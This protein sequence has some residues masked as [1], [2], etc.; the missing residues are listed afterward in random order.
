MT[1]HSMKTLL[2]ISALVVMGAWAAISL[3]RAIQQGLSPQGGDDLYTYWYAGQFLREG[4]DLYKT[5]IDGDKP[6]LPVVYLDRTVTDLKEIIQ[7]NLVP[8]PASS[9]LAFFLLAPLAF[10]SWSLAKAVWLLIN[11]VLLGCIPFLVYRLF[12]DKGWLSPWE[13]IALTCAMIGLSSTRN[14]T[15][16]GQITFLI[17][18]LMLAAVVLA[19]RRPW[20][21]GLLLGVAL[22]KYSLSLGVLLLFLLL[23]PKIRLVLTACLVQLAGLLALMFIS[24][25]GLPA[26][27]HEYLLMVNLH[28]SMEG[29]HLAALVRGSGQEV[30]IGL[31]WTL[32]VAIPIAYWRWAKA[33]RRFGEKLV[34]LSRIHLLT[35]LILWA[36]LVVYH[37]AYDAMVVIVYMGLIA[38]LVKRSQ[39]WDLSRAARFWIIAFSLAGQLL[40]MIPSGSMTRGYLPAL[41]ETVWGRV[42][43]LT[44]TFLILAF[45]GVGLF[46]LFRLRREPAA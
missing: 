18:D 20:L 28:A 21:A 5:F 41:L 10:L 26:I 45:L 24:G 6:S 38:Y 12:Q 22:S 4:K 32:V 27:I 37:R 15:A 33:L 31:A 13:G 23:E 35:I 39:A 9:P 19:D 46:L 17:L 40:L 16:S 8:A 11:L 42:E 14:A 1:N 36:L 25:S 29:I 43:N 44:T 2:R 3:F 30:W 34:P 7:P